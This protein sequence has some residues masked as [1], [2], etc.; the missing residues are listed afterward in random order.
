M[1][2]EMRRPTEKDVEN[3]IQGSTFP[4]TAHREALRCQLFDTSLPLMP[5]DLAAVAG[6][7]AVSDQEKWETWPGEGRKDK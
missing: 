1:T 6:G 5:E 7:N 2:A 3:I 4:N